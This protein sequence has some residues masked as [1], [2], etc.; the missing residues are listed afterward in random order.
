M[1][2]KALQAAD[3]FYATIYPTLT[4]VSEYSLIN[5]ELER[6]AIPF[7]TTGRCAEWPAFSYTLTRN[8]VIWE[9][10]WGWER[11]EFIVR[12]CRNGGLD[13]LSRGKLS[14]PTAAEEGVRNGERAREGSTVC[15][16]SV[17]THKRMCVYMFLYVFV[18]VCI[19]V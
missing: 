19:S 11:V 2:C 6:F 1:F 4:R 13:Y 15:V 18:C 16:L 3:Q 5:V 9:Q 10:E 14:D 7:R 12:G 17:R 8:G